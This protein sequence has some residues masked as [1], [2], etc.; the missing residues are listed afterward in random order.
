MTQTEAE[1]DFAI[2]QKQSYGYD[3]SGNKHYNEYTQNWVAN[4]S[5]VEYGNAPR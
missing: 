5:K 2:E 4:F 1:I 3:Y